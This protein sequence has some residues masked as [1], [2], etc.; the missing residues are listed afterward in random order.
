MLSRCTNK[1]HP[2]YPDYGGRGIAVCDRWSNSFENFLTD[3]GE[4]PSAHHS[5][6]RIDVNGIYEPKNC[7]WALKKEQANNT[8]RNRYVVVDGQ[9]L[10]R[11]Q[12]LDR[13]GLK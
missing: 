6:D 5:L 10:T 11:S 9:R 1:N 13:V 12:Y 4:R 7:R 3:M 8:R 2:S